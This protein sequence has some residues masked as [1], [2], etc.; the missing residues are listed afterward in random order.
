MTSKD[1]YCCPRIKDIKDDKKESKICLN[2]SEKECWEVLDDK[3]KG[4]K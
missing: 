2:C 3:R 1:K 4:A